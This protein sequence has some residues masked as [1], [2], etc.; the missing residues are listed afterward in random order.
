MMYRKI[1]LLTLCTSI[2]TSAGTADPY[3]SNAVEV[4]NTEVAI[5][6]GGASGTY[7]AVRLREDFNTSIV[8]IEPRDHLGG[9][10]STYT[11]PETNTTLE[12]GVQSYVRNQ[13]AIDFL[14]R[15]KINT[16]PFAAKRLTTIT[17]D[18]N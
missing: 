4:I 3:A 16:L 12:Y 13:A 10:V 2:R 1:A 15:F 18:V 14:A 8:V 5:V 11:V 6:G 9:H 17:V 7:A